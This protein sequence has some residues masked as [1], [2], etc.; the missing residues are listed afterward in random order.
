MHN[1]NKYFFF[2]H[3]MLD[4]IIQKLLN[5]STKLIK[6]QDKFYKILQNLW[7]LK[8]NNTL[9]FQLQIWENK[10]KQKDDHSLYKYFQ[11]KSNLNQLCI[12]DTI[13]FLSKYIFVDIKY[14][15]LFLFFN[16]DQIEWCLFLHDQFFLYEWNWKK[17]INMNKYSY[18]TIE[19]FSPNP[20]GYPHIAH[21]RNLAIGRFIDRILKLFGYHTKMSILINDLGWQAVSFWDDILYKLFINLSLFKEYQRTYNIDRMLPLIFHVQKA[22][23]KRLK[24][25]L[26]TTMFKKN[27]HQTYHKFFFIY[28]RINYHNVWTFILN[29][30]FE[31]LVDTKNNMHK[32]KKYFDASYYILHSLINDII[33]SKLNIYTNKI[34]KLYDIRKCVIKRESIVLKSIFKYEQLSFFKY[35]LKHVKNPTNSTLNWLHHY[36]KRYLILKRLMQV[37]D[38]LYQD[39]SIIMKVKDPY[40]IEKW[41]KQF[42]VIWKSSIHDDKTTYVLTDLV[43]CCILYLNVNRYNVIY[44]KRRVSFKGHILV[45]GY[46]HHKYVLF[47]DKFYTSIFKWS[48]LN[49]ILVG[50]VRLD[51]QKLSKWWS[52]T[53]SLVSIIKFINKQILLSSYKDM[54]IQ[55]LNQLDYA[56]ILNLFFYRFKR[57]EHVN[58]KLHKNF[59]MLIIETLYR[60]K[61][62]LIIMWNIIDQYKDVK[63]VKYN[64]KNVFI[65]LHWNVQSY[66]ECI[67][68]DILRCNYILIKAWD[69]FEPNIVLNYL[70]KIKYYVE[71]LFDLGMFNLTFKDSIYVNAK[72]FFIYKKD[73]RCFL[74]FLINWL[75]TVYKRCY[76]LLF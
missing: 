17:C 35:I 61:L 41:K 15:K 12:D 28:R 62:N 18:Y 48:A 29:L 59:N 3:L 1:S 56:N 25:F 30:K 34:L 75:L 32:L 55:H 7:S 76:K 6:K 4:F 22:F 54:Y 23:Q 42:E 45:V 63:Y 31:N 16:I 21:L 74:Y 10:L 20:T 50:M 66:I 71:Y 69:Q 2:Q 44:K 60:I 49:S 40:H 11:F 37:F 68:I 26:F 24:W 36:S 13:N 65:I 58:V 43:L 53:L 27:M 46:D 8:K 9:F 14:S 38:I 33:C 39:K 52:H 70:I 72:L 57:S 19:C 73:V 51:D 5:T 67:F 64:F 47:V